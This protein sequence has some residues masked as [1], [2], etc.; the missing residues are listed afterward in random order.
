M[1]E[2]LGTESIMWKADKTLQAYLLQEAEA[3]SRAAKIRWC[4]QKGLEVANLQHDGI[5]VRTWDESQWSAKDIER[6]MEQAASQ[7][8]RA[9]MRCR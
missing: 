6:G 4:Q 1:I 8:K 7:R 2:N 3:T 9:D 5:F